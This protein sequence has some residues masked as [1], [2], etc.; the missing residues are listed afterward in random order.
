M[1]ARHLVL[2]RHG[3]SAWNAEHRLQGQADA[4]LS[5]RGREQA[6]ALVATL[7]ELPPMGVVTSDLSRARDTAQLA[8]FGDAEPDPR[9]RERGL[10]VWEGR[11]EA[12]VDPAGMRHFRRTD[13]P[14]E[15]GERWAGLEARVGAAIADLAAR[16]GSWLVF[17]HGGCVRA[18][19]AHLTGADHRTVAGPANASLTVLEHRSRW[20]L[21]AF[22]WFPAEGGVLRLEPA[23]D[24]GG[25]GTAVSNRTG[26]LEAGPAG[27]PRG[28]AD[29]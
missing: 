7:A 29:A 21:R 8:G 10:G 3:E 15:G 26:G 19:V 17:T 13:D 1:S 23:S 4:P 14:P 5:E 12:E 11:L 9:W 2:V 18:A 28:H 16:G 25:A 27:A 22:N 24:P 20:R 6:R